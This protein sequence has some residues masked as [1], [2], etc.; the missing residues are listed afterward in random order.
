[1]LS[2][3]WAQWGCWYKFQPLERIRRYFGEEVAF[4]FLWLGLST[5]LS[6]R[7]VK[8]VHVRVHA[9][10]RAYLIFTPRLCITS[11]YLQLLVTCQD[12]TREC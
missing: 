7:N 1:M 2:K 12:F 4:Y 3:T 5:H 8:H 9:C 10:M 6:R 11:F